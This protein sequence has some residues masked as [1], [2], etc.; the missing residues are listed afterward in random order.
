VPVRLRTQGAFNDAPSSP[1]RQK[2]PPLVSTGLAGLLSK[3]ADYYS[4]EGA[5]SVAMHTG[6]CCSLHPADFDLPSDESVGD[7]SSED[8]HSPD[9]GAGL[10]LLQAAQN[11]ERLL[12]Q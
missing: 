3:T 6:V 11:C 9:A 8:D 1:K 4:D 12:A 10:S 5:S 7:I 2:S